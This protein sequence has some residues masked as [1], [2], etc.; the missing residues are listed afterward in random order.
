MPFLKV[1]AGVMKLPV[2]P[3]TSSHTKTAA[4]LGLRAV[5]VDHDAAYALNIL[6]PFT[7]HLFSV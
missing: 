5:A 4:Q 7:V 3:G 6:F 1:P 2:G